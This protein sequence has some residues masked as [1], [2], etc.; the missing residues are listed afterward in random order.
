MSDTICICAKFVKNVYFLL[1]KAEMPVHK[2][3]I[4]TYPRKDKL[5][6]LKFENQVASLEQTCLSRQ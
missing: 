5:K 2:P 4:Q 6:H 3:K 1:L